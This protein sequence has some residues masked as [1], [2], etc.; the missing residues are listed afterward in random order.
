MPKD[1]QLAATLRERLGSESQG[2]WILFMDE[3][4]QQLPFLLG[5]AGRPTAESIESSAISRA[6]FTSW[7]EMIETAPQRGGLGW[8]YDTYKSWKKA[9]AVVLAHPFIRELALTASEVNT[10]ARE[11]EQWPDSPEALERFREERKSTLNARRENSV[12]ALQAQLEQ[13]R[14]EEEGLRTELAVARSRAA[15]LEALSARLQTDLSASQALAGSLQAQLDSSAA[16]LDAATKKLQ[17]NEKALK[18]HQTTS[19]RQQEQIKAY[20]SRSWFQQLRDLFR[21]S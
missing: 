6:G 10:I 12:Q 2:Q 9:Y 7:R 19:K 18:F 4:S 3:I 14:V 1:T 21:R 16:K 17:F 15:D 11:S 8:S 20:E 5:G 13:K